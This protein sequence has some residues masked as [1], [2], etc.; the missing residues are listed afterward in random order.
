MDRG[1]SWRRV[2]GESGSDLQPNVNWSGSAPAWL[3]AMTPTGPCGWALLLFPIA[4]AAFTL[5]LLAYLLVGGIFYRGA[6]AELV[7]AA[8]EFGVAPIV[9]ELI[10]RVVFGL[11][12]AV[13]NCLPAAALAVLIAQT[14]RRLPKG[15]P[16]V[17]LGGAVFTAAT[18]WLLV[19]MVTDDSSTA[20]LLL[21]FLPIMLGILLVP[22]A[23]L[24]VLL[25]WLRGP[26]LKDGSCSSCHRER[27]ASETF[28]CAA[29][30]TAE[31]HVVTVADP[32]SGWTTV[33]SRA[34]CR[35]RR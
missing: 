12:A 19:D 1:T 21:L 2:E 15:M 33:Q 14:S 24:T 28:G 3:D 22:F 35:T 30:G 23:G 20:A 4:S 9:C 5:G 10:I 8:G 27:T 7:D 29:G 16:V 34:A 17:L 18:V 32:A 26:S 11:L 25:H 31:R 6:W 13:Y